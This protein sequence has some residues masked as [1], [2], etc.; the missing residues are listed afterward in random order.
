MASSIR[1]WALG[2]AV[3]TGGCAT[4]PAPAPRPEPPALT[5]ED[6]LGWMMRLE[7]ERLLRDPNPPPPVVLAPA[8]RTE[9]AVVAPAPPSDLLRLL[10]DGEARVRRRAALALGRVGLRDAVEPLTALLT[11]PETDVRQ[12]AAFALGLIGDR[13]AR[14]ALLE[15]LADSDPLVQGRAV[16][17][18]GMIADRTDAIAVSAM[19]RAH[20]AAG[21]LTGI[22]SDDLSY[23]LAPPVEAVRLGLYALV[24]LGSYEA[25]AA[26]AL[27]QGGRPVST[28][29]P[30]AYA[31]Q[32]LGD[33]QAAPALLTLLDTPGRYTA[34]FAARGLGAMKAAPGVAPLRQ[35]VAQRTAPPAVVI[36]AI[37]ALG[38]IGSADAAPVLTKIVADA[39]ADPTLR[40]E[41]MQAFV[42]VATADSLDLLLDLL[43]DS[44]PSIRGA[45]MRALARV[46]PDSF[47]LTL[48]GLDPDRDWTV[49]AAQAASLGS[50]P[51]GRGLPGLEVLVQD[52]DLRLLPAIFTALIAS[53]SPEAEA[54]ITP[55]LTADDFT[56]RAAAAN[57]LAELKAA[58]AVP[59]LL[60]A[61]N[62]SAGD[63][64]YVARAA[65]LSALARIDPSAAQPLLQEALGDRDWAVRM[66]AA[67]LLRERTQDAA[68]DA[69]IRPA[70]AG[71]TVTDEEWK[72]LIAP[73]FS[74][75]AYLD[76]D[77]G[78]VQIELA[79]L[80]APLTVAN[81][82]ALARKKFFDGVA[83]HRV[84][85]DFVVQDG[86]PRGDSEGGPGYTI[87]DEINTRPYLR[88]TVGMALDWED[89]GGSQ[90]FITHS[91]Q[92]HLDGRYTVFGH[93][94]EGIEV[95][96]R[97]RP[98]DIIRRVRIWD[99]ITEPE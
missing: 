15:T 37:R 82:V 41:A 5:W 33:P 72:W 88:G 42:T 75:H 29:W 22:A 40:Q 59:A 93:V 20:V 52:R 11:D 74:P 90:F 46:D 51:G 19:I 66:R 3:A 17:A 83:I 56:V 14:P 18:L 91:P 58:A 38:A 80:D 63:S 13:A 25:L 76:T 6:K 85:P 28:W 50:L 31:L 36:Q 10:S 95:V 64:T 60:A 65:V 26:A 12:M 77:R 30:I 53:K 73:P 16:E 98:G 9:P 81:F 89:T 54:L 8:T 86:D 78:T 62:A 1:H 39:E 34:A 23:P 92:P 99:G 27:D 47:L 35:I 94:I 45:A 96:D 68:V 70:P 7:D 21:A 67:A 61:Y 97:L 24:R 48:S 43:T 71:R 2:L 4:V 69:A 57:A 87:R 32:R 49:R 55:H 79:I 44:S 84:V